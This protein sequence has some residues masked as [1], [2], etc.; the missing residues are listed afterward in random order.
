[1]KPRRTTSIDLR[2]R[3]LS[4]YDG[5]EHTRQEVAD[6]FKVSLGMVKKLI[7]QRS[8]IGS[9]APLHHLAG[10]KPEILET[11]REEMKRAKSGR[12]H[13]CRSGKDGRFFDSAGPLLK[14]LLP[15]TVV[16][17]RCRLKRPWPVPRPFG[18]QDVHRI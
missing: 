9:I 3:I 11:H 18:A 10:R 2:E 4:V 15:Q 14:Q 5:G 16:R 8:K 17:C 6:R 1:M 12:P 13:L 7:Q